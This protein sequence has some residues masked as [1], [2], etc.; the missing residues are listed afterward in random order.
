MR[1]DPGVFPV[2]G[3]IDWEDSGLDIRERDIAKAL[4][5]IV[6]D[7]TEWEV[8]AV[9]E[10]YSDIARYDRERLNYAMIERSFVEACILHKKGNPMYVDGIVKA[11][12]LLA[13]WPSR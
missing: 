2:A 1:C 6:R 11:G 12:K 10:G 4:T 8:M 3:I 5:A 9:L 13:V 7:M